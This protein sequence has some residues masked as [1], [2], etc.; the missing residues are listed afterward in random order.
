MKK[1]LFLFI[2]IHTIS[3]SQQNVTT[4]Y[5]I[6]HSEKMDQSENPNLSELGKKRAENWKNIFSEITFDAIYS[7]DYK[8]TIETVTPTANSKNIT[9]TITIYNPKTINIEEF[10][11]ATTS[12][13]ILIVGHSNSTPTFVNKILNDEK[14]SKIDETVFG[15][16]YIISIITD[17]S[18]HSQLLKLE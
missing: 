14:Y 7:T 12:K 3:W 9:I 6:R 4:Y 1:L 18:T 8:R 5:F 10:K 17:G 2:F 15:N 11:K 13:T 16:L